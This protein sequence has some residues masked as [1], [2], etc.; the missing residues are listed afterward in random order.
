MLNFADGHSEAVLRKMVIDPNHRLWRSRW[1]ND[2]EPHY[3]TTW[4]VNPLTENR[5]DP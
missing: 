1:N 4:S 3:E 2:N 5:I